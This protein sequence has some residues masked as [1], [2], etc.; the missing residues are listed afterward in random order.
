MALWSW[1]TGMAF[2]YRSDFPQFESSRPRV[3]GYKRWRTTRLMHWVPRAFLS[4]VINFLTVAFA[5]FAVAKFYGWAASDNV[6]KRQVKCKY[7]RKR[8]SEKVSVFSVA[9][10]LER[11]RL[12]ISKG[13]YGRLKWI[14]ILLTRVTRR[15]DA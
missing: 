14:S 1:S 6:I 3:F 4:K 2:L 13:G 10:N 12:D 11:N 8:I 5:L 7:C 9:V 15:S